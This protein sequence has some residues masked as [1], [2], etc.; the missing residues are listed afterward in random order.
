MCGSEE[1]IASSRG[2]EAVMDDCR[3]GNTN[4]VSVFVRFKNFFE[5]KSEEC[6][7]V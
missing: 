4:I 5:L 3:T 1:E 2:M 6:W 7:R